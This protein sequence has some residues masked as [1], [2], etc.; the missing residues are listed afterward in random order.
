M[1]GFDIEVTA[2]S[3]RMGAKGLLRAT[4][5]CKCNSQTM[6]VVFNEHLLC[7]KWA[8]LTLIEQRYNL[9]PDKEAGGSLVSEM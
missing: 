3:S 9:Q 2:Q 7:S 1:G 6:R 4:K 8:F 5:T